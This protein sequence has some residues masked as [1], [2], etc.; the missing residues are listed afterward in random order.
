MNVGHATDAPLE[1]VPDRVALVVDREVLT[2]RQLERRIRQVATALV[3]AGVRA[4]DR[5][6]LVNLGSAL[7]VATIFGAARVG[8]AT[9]QMNA[10][11]TSGELGQ[12]A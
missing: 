1:A 9:A 6:A 8:A 11:L 7:S 12:L 5:V 4:G 10:Y 2:Y 3:T